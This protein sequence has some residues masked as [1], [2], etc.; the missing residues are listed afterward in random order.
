MPAEYEGALSAT[1]PHAVLSGGGAESFL[2]RSERFRTRFFRDGSV[3]FASMSSLL[4]DVLQNCGYIEFSH[5]GRN[6]MN[7]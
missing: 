3:D 5:R 2:I 7:L 4:T 1:I 6:Y